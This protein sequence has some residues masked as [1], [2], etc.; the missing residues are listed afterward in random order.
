VLNLTGVEVI[1]I[2]PGLRTRLLATLTDPNVAYIL[3]LIGIWGL[4]FEFTHPGIFAPGVFGSICL[5]LGLFA[6]SVIPINL[7]GLALTLLGIALMAAEAFV[8]SFGA[9]GIGGVIAFLFGSMMTFDTPGYRLAWPVIVGAAIVS[10]AL[11]VLVL[12]MLVRVRRRPATSGDATLLG[13][14]AKVLDWTGMEGE[15]QALGERWH[16]RAENTLSIGQTVRVV[17]RDGLTLRVEPI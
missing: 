15:V 14:K 4:I 11:V 17:E 5:L 1:R 3:I 2:E 7:A 12:A 13:A 9:L 16:A 6:L 10:F 8:P